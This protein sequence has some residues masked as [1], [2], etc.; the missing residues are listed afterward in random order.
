MIL[1][2]IDKLVVFSTVAGTLLSERIQRHMK[3]SSGLIY[4]SQGHSRGDED[5]ASCFPAAVLLESHL[6]R[7][8]VEGC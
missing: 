6:Y 1:V 2:N 4:Q 7:T 8:H 3:E 5:Y